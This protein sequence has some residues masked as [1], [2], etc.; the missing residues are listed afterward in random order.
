VG[1]CTRRR[2]DAPA[3]DDFFAD[4]SA[5]SVVVEVL[6]P[7]NTRAEMAERERH[8]LDNGVTTHVELDLDGQVVYANEESDLVAALRSDFP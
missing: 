1:R 7:S 8:Y 4:E 3:G 6:S 2:A 5:P